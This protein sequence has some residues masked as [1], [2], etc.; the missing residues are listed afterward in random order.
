M[1]CGCLGTEVEALQDRVAEYGEA[2]RGSEDEEG[3]R[4]WR[5]KL[6][7]RSSTEEVEE[8]HATASGAGEWSEQRCNSSIQRGQQRWWQRWRS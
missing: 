6:C 3:W 5:C 4:C 8:L 2:R 1:L 7:C